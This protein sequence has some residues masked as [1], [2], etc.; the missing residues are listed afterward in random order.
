MECKD[1]PSVYRFY[2][3]IVESVT[4]DAGSILKTDCFNEAQGDPMIHGSLVHRTRLLEIDPEA[5]K[6]AEARYPELIIDAGDIRALPYP[7]DSFDLV[8]DLST[9]D[10]VPDDHYNQALSEYRRVLKPGGVLAFVV[11]LHTG[12]VGFR[13]YSQ[14]EQYNF[15]KDTFEKDLA[16][17]FEVKATEHLFSQPGR[18]ELHYYLLEKKP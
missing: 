3:S 6:K 16:I 5:I 1:Y 13:P 2:H 17:R 8:I 9:L 10:H 7:M 14:V 4:V 15:H 11:W 18:R 12:E